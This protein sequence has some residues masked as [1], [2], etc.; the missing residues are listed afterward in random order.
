MNVYS[1]GGAMWSAA[2]KGAIE[3]VWTD[4]C[5][6][7]TQWVAEPVKLQH[8]EPTE[9]HKLALPPRQALGPAELFDELLAKEARLSKVL[10]ALENEEHELLRRDASA[11]KTL[12]AKE[13]VS[14]AGNA[15]QW[16][17]PQEQKQKAR[18]DAKRERQLSRLRVGKPQPPPAKGVIDAVRVL[19]AR[20]RETA[21]EL[22]LIEAQLTELSDTALSAEGAGGSTTTVNVLQTSSSL[23]AL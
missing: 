20:E 17:S 7:P 13:G 15:A 6:A 5:S 23:P 12:F 21:H 14:L 22:A 4:P 16:L 3:H 9:A 10:D 19:R 18:D 1:A 11:S 2:E 8:P